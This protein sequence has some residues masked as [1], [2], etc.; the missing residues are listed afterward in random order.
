MLRVDPGKMVRGEFYASHDWR[1]IEQ[2]GSGNEI[3]YQVNEVP[4]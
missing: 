4:I 2:K 3:S 1:L